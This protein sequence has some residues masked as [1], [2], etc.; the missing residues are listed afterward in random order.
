VQGLEMNNVN[1]TDQNAIANSFNKYFVSIADKNTEKLESNAPD[2]GNIMNPIKLMR[3]NFTDQ[4]PKINW[5]YTWTAEVNRFIKS[6]KTLVDM[7]I[8]RLEYSK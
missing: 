2:Q 8:F 5:S 6:L 3:K 4:C 1:I 7:K